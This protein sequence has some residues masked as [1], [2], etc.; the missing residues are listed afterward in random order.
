MRHR[1]PGQKNRAIV[2]PLRCSHIDASDE[3]EAASSCFLVSKRLPLEWD[4]R[5]KKRLSA[6]ESGAWPR[7][8][9]ID[10]P[11][12]PA[13]HGELQDVRPELHN[14]QKSCYSFGLGSC[15]KFRV[16]PDVS[17]KA[18]VLKGTALKQRVRS[19]MT[20][21]EAREEVVSC[22]VMKIFK[23]ELTNEKNFFIISFL[24]C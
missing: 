20:A 1:P 4:A 16:Y 21:P 6:Q 5:R 13:L 14:L 11:D 9:S 23:T 10:P 24:C 22:S 7:C 19:V 12:F 3:A 17:R 15:R 2:R 18:K 8:E